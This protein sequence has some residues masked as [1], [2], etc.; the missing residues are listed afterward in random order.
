MRVPSSSGA[1]RSERSAAL[2]ARGVGGQRDDG[3][4]V[5]GLGPDAA[6]AD[7]EDG[8]DGVAARADQQ[9]DARRRHRLDEHARVGV[10]AAVAVLPRTRSR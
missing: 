7:G 2:D 6:Q 3:D 4:V 8:Y 9:L 1:A 5:E 10:T